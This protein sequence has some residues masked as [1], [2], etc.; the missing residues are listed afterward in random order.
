[1][2][3]ELFQVVWNI[4]VLWYIVCTKVQVSWF[5]SFFFLQSIN[6]GLEFEW[7]KF[8]VLWAFNNWFPCK[9]LASLHGWDCGLRAL[10]QQRWLFL[11]LLWWDQPSNVHVYAVLVQLLSCVWLFASHVLQHTRLPCPSLSPGVCSNSCPL[12]QWCHPTISSSVAPFSSCPQ[13]FPASGSF[14]I[15]QLFASAGQSIGAS[16]LASVLP[17]N[18]QDWSPLGL[19]GLISLQSKGL[20]RVSPAPQFKS[21]DT[22]ALSLLYGL[23]LTSVHDYWKEHSFDYIEF[24]WQSDV[25]AF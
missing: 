21:I 17:M 22:L 6:F 19:T 4:P 2:D 11:H 24:C 9:S 25:F 10:T 1:M 14:P 5:G 23:A 13:S 8:W 16:A 18:I 12:S 3:E 15:S 20:S 7:S